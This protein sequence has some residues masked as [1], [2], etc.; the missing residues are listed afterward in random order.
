VAKGFTW[1][2]TLYAGSAPHYARGRTAYRPDLGLRVVEA[3]G[4]GDRARALDVGCGPGS[5]TLLLA[6]C[7]QRVVG[8]DAD[9]EMLAE[10][11]ERAQRAGITGVCWRR[12][13]AEELPDGLGSFDLITFAQSFHWMEGDRVA[14]TVRGMLRAGGACVHVHATTHRGEAGDD[15]LPRP[16]PPY[17]RIDALVASFLG[18]AKRAGRSAPP[19]IVPG[20]E[21]LDPGARIVG[22]R[23]RLHPEPPACARVGRPMAQRAAD[24][25][26]E[27]PEPPRA[28]RPARSVEALAADERDGEHLG[29]EVGGELRIAEPARHA[30]EHHARVPAVEDGERRRLIAWPAAAPRPSAL[31]VPT[32]A[33]DSR[34]PPGV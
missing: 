27:D 32:S 14:R 11:A 31:A 16:R 23:D 22:E 10:A 28:R 8:V 24:L 33:P 18:P 19:A 25:V 30:G 21:L 2:E 3:A 29:A 17:D 26:G 5:L 15:P 20:S 1:D 34:E 9:R 4:V 12:M 13:R 7:V 6:G